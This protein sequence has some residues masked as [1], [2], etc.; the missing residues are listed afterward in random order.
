M[1]GAKPSPNSDNL[2]DTNPSLLNLKVKNLINS[3]GSWNTNMIYNFFAE[4]DI[5]T[6]L[7]IPISPSFDKDWTYWTKDPKG[8]Y[9]VKRGYYKAWLPYWNRMASAKDLTRI[10]PSCRSFMKKHLWHLPGPKVWIT[11]LWKI[12]TNSVAVGKEFQKRSLDGVCVCFLCDHMEIETLEHLFRDCTFAT[13][14]W[15][16]SH[17]GINSRQ[18]HDLCLQDWIINWLSLM[19]KMSDPNEVIVS[20]LCTLWTIWRARNKA[21]LGEHSFSLKGAIDIYEDSL[22]KAITAN[23]NQ[24]KSL[25]SI[26]SDDDLD[27]DL[28][29]LRKGYKCKLIGISYNCSQTTIHVDAAWKDDKSTGLGWYVNCGNTE[30]YFYQRWTLLSLSADQAEAAVIL[31]ALKWALGRN[32][33]HITIFFD[34]LQMFVQIMDNSKIGLKTKVLVTD[35][36][37]LCSMFHCISFCFIP[38]KYNKMAHNIA[39][40]AVNM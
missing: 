27:C 24:S 4:N 11:L 33:Y 13:R 5:T 22:S 32:I 28:L 9:S 17:L 2:L 39:Q 25:T 31:E 8:D 35:I 6:I 30:S 3:D 16:G 37:N 36:L 29:N 12:L 1:N 40:R 19:L 23:N 34:C 26:V 14:I 20:F 38:R 15:R 18:R 21:A 10:S 7:A